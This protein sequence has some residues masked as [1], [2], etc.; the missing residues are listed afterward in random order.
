MVRVSGLETGVGRISRPLGGVGVQP[1][2]DAGLDTTRCIESVCKVPLGAGEYD[3]M[4]PAWRLE[5]LLT[6]AM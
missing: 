4:Y 2:P 6:I 1:M 5:Y 3:C